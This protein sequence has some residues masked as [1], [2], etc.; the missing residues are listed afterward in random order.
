MAKKNNHESRL[1]IIKEIIGVVTSTESVDSITN[2]ILDLALSYTK[3]HNGSIL[4][5]NGN[6]TLVVKA[7][8]GIDHEVIPT[9][10]IKLGEDICGRI[11]KEKTPVLVK[12][13]KTDERFRGIRNGKYKTGSFISCPILIHDKPFGVINITDKIDGTPFTE[14]EFDLINVLASQTAVSLQYAGLVNELR[15]KVS[16]V[17]ERNKALIDSDRLKNEFVATM[18]HEF[19]TPLNSI[20]GAIYYLK[21]KRATGAER[22]EFINI[23]SDETNRLI[24]LLTSLLNFSILEKERPFLSQKVLSFKVLIEEVVASRIV[25][26]ILAQNNITIKISCPD[27][28]PDIIGDKIRLIQ[29][30]IHLID[31]VTRYTAAGDT[32]SLKVTGKD[33]TVD[34]GLFIK[35]RKI[36]ETEL[37]FL[38]DERSIW[39]EVDEIKNKLKF[40]LS[41]KII[42]LHKGALSIFN[43]PAGITVHITFPRSVQEYSSAEINELAGLFLSFTAETMNLN[44]CSLMLSDEAT[45][46]LTIRSAIGFDEDI[47]RGTRIRAGDNIAGWVA[48]ENK[49]LLIE[50]IENFPRLGKKS[51]AQYNTKS[52][53]CLPITINGKVLG[54]L[55]LNNKVN[56][57]PFNKKD[58]YYASTL[59]DRFAQILKKV[60]SGKVSA[61]GFK[62]ITRSMENLHNAAR[63]YRKKNWETADLILKLMQNMQCSEDEIKLAIYASSLYDLGL[64]Q[65]DENILMKSGE[66]SHI[67]QRLIKTH[68]FPV[69]G[70]L[71]PIE[72][73]ETVTETILHHH[74]R[75]DGS[76]YPDGLKGDIIPFMARVL[77]VVDTYTAMTSDRPYRKAINKKDALKQIKSG[78]GTQFDPQVVDSFTR[79][80]HTI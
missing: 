12:D 23:I 33:S 66:L 34:I 42:E 60:K 59:T 45:G 5:S 50:D 27:S 30:L 41:K 47:V 53:L 7:A 39:T 52:L 51:A 79:I 76:G 29:S 35:G 25:K 9:I 37:P 55:N 24:N 38:F 3:A 57:K 26:D 77:A 10:K 73:D 78:A 67:E 64:T 14:D 54:V 21:E 36:P 56:S 20:T 46:E 74:E 18:S 63:Q 70:L 13:L 11:V 65:L 1:A 16:E 40:Y 19:R 28:L 61:A 80:M 62:R 4:L 17:D 43:A 32:I 49:P 44:K 68:P 69:V 71:E 48:A 75:Y 58:L 15:L 8:K 72:T 31:G 22:N 2:L 6:G